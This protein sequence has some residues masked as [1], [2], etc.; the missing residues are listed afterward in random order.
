[1]FGRLLS[2]G[3]GLMVI[4]AVTG[5]PTHVWLLVT[6]E[7]ETLIKPCAGWVPVFT[8]VNAPIEFPEPLANKPIVELELV[9]VYC[10]PVRLEVKLMAVVD[11]PLQT[12]WLEIPVITGVGNTTILKV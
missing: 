3:I 7:G 6:N 8:P 12:V 10:V 11:A 5:D 2:T 4:V 9:Q 1:M